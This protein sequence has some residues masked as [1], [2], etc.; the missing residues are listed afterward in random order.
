MTKH[1]PCREDG[2]DCEA[3]QP[4][5]QDKCLKMLA[6]QLCAGQERRAEKAAKQKGNDVVGMLTEDSIRRQ[7]RKKKQY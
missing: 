5:C 6:A 2:K 1:W 3:R 4:G 7:R